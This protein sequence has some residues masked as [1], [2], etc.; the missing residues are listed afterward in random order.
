MEYSVQRRNG[1]SVSQYGHN[2]YCTAILCIQLIVVVELINLARSIPPVCLLYVAFARISLIE[3]Q[4][5]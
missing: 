2:I 4:L 5:I 3:V 1:Y